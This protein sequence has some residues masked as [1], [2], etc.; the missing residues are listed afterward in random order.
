MMTK[1]LL[2]MV[3][4]LAVSPALAALPDQPISKAEYKFGIRDIKQYRNTVTFVIPGEARKHQQKGD[5]VEL[6]GIY[7]T[8][9]KHTDT[10]PV[11]DSHD[12]RKDVQQYEPFSGKARIVA[13][14]DDGDMAKRAAEAGCLLIE[15]KK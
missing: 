1:T 4:L 10:C 14:F 8:D 13:T 7:A 5:A 6:S 11:V 2:L 9:G 12:V 15:D 3:A